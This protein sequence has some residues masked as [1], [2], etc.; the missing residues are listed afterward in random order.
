MTNSNQSSDQ[1]NKKV[2]IRY[3]PPTTNL[4]I[5][6]VFVLGISVGISIMY[7]YMMV[8]N[9]DPF[10]ELKENPTAVRESE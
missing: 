9:P 4:R 6:A 1:Q 7:L 3:A 8:R 10:A 5:I 2:E